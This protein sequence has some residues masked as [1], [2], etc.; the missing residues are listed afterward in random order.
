ME[1]EAHK[2]KM[3][4]SLEDRTLLM[5]RSREVPTVR[6]PGYLEGREDEEEVRLGHT[7]GTDYCSQLPRC[8]LALHSPLVLLAA[9]AL[10]LD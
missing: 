6:L 2:L 1:R 5:G 4:A 7:E 10:P 9:A 3:N 8:R